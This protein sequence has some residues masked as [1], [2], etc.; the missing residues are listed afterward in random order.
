MLAGT[1]IQAAVALAAVELPFTARRGPALSSDSTSSLVSRMLAKRGADDPAGPSIDVGLTPSYNF[2]YAKVKFGTPTQDLELLLDTGSPITWVYGPNTTYNDAPQFTPSDSKSFVAYNT[3]LYASY[4]SGQYIGYWGQDTVEVPAATYDL[5]KQ[6]SNLAQN[7]IF[8]VVESFSA[9]AGAPGLLGLGPHFEGAGPSNYTTLPEALYNQNITESPAFSVYLEGDEGKLILGGWDH[10]QI[11]WPIYGFQH[12]QARDNFY[13][14]PFTQLVLN[15]GDGYD[16]VNT[17]LLDTGSPMSLVPPGFV[18]KIGEQYNLTEYAKYGT[19]Y[20]TEDVSNL[21]G[22]VTFRL[23]KFEI[24]IPVKDLFVPGEYIWMDD[25]PKNVTSL[26]LIGSPNYL[27]GDVFF[28]HV[29]TVFDTA[30]KMVY[31]SRR[32]QN[33]L[34]VNDTIVPFSED[35]DYIPGEIN[36]TANAQTSGADVTTTIF[37]TSTAPLFANLYLGPTAQV[38]AEEGKS[39]L[40]T[41]SSADVMSSGLMLDTKTHSGSADATSAAA[42]TSSPAS[43]SSSQNGASVAGMS[44]MLALLAFLI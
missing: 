15:H 17:A 19:Y 14:V 18:K 33:P 29:Y 37:V 12:I 11:E 44:G 24:D 23:G 30:D 8:G 42:T 1:L 20:T 38:K 25:G 31:L 5:D 2:Y 32:R 39:V 6:G 26:S 10:N 9:A 43:S 22:W 21:E 7:F 34:P 41:L 27:L 3:S 40:A 16:V 13:R 36:V 28:R 4:G 35:V